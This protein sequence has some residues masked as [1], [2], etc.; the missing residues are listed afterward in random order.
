[1]ELDFQQVTG[2]PPLDA[3]GA[4]EVVDLR[5]VDVSDLVGVVVVRYLSACP[6]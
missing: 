3:H 2:L 5:E 1:V 6:V 4:G